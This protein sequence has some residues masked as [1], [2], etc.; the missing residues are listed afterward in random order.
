MEEQTIH[1]N[2][3]SDLASSLAKQNLIGIAMEFDF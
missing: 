3:A 1:I 2:L